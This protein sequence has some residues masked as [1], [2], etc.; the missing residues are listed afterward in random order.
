MG[1]SNAMTKKAT[2]VSPLSAIVSSS[3]K[4]FTE[5]VCLVIVF[6]GVVIWYFSPQTLG[7]V[8]LPLQFRINNVELTE[9][10][11]EISDLRT[12]SCWSGGYIQEVGASAMTYQMSTRYRFEI[13]NGSD[14]TIA[15]SGGESSTV[16]LL[17]AYPKSKQWRAVALPDNSRWSED[18]PQS[19]PKRN[20]IEHSEVWVDP[21]FRSIV[22]SLV[23][24][25]V[26]FGVSTGYDLYAIP[27]SADYSTAQYSS[28][29]WTHATYIDEDSRS[30]LPGHSYADA[31]PGYSSWSFQLPVDETLGRKLNQD[32]SY[33]P[34]PEEVRRSFIVVGIAVLVPDGT[35]D[36]QLLGFAPAA[37]PGNKASDDF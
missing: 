34:S 35:G 23:K 19:R 20:P 2:A 3:S 30:L 26:E 10:G 18:Y 25:G 17:V 21:G 13:Y 1:Q 8:S 16:R 36:T 29:T 7:Y 14:R 12:C 6:G 22:P 15:I 32:A 9:L 24:N 4:K 33:Q 11:V 27:A 5:L 31:R 37:Y 28:G